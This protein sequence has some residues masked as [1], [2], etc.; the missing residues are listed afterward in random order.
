MINE[1]ENSMIIKTLIENFFPKEE[2]IQLLSNY[3]VLE[4]LL[5][6]TVSSIK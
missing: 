5:L 3:D 1:G 2:A 6:E 4:K